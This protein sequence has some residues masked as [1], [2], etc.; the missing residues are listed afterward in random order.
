MAAVVCTPL[1][2]DTTYFGDEGEIRTHALKIRQQPPSPARENIPMKPSSR[3]FPV[4]QCFRCGST[5]HLANAAECRARNLQCRYSAKAEHDKNL[6]SPLRSL[7]RTPNS[8][9][10]WDPTAEKSF[11]KLKQLLLE[12]PALALF[13]PALETIVTTDAS[14]DGIGA[15]LSQ[16]HDGGERT[17][18]F[19][20]HTL[21]A[22]E[23]KYS[24]V[25]K[26]A[27]ACIWAVE[28]WRCWLWADRA[29][30]RIARWSVK[31]MGFNYDVKYKPGYVN[32]VADAHCRLPAINSHEIAE[33]EEDV[34]AQITSEI[35]AVAPSELA[36]ATSKCSVLSQVL[37]YMEVGWPDNEKSLS[38]ELLPFCRVRYELAVRNG[39]IIRGTGRLVI[40]E[41]LQAS[42]IALAHESHQGTVRT[43]ARLRRLFWWPKWDTAVQ[44]YVRNCTVRRTLDKTAVQYRA[45]LNPVPLQNPAWEKLAIDIVGP[46]QNSRYG[47]RLAITLVDYYKL[48]VKFSQNVTT[49]DAIQFL[50]EIF[51]HEGL[52]SEIFSDNGAQFVSNEFKQFLND[53]AI[54]HCRTSLYYP[55]AN[56]EVE[57][58]NRV[59]KHCLQ[60]ASRTGRPR[61]EVVTEFLMHYRA[62]PHAVTGEFSKFPFLTSTGDGAD[63]RNLLAVVMNVTENGFYRLGTA[64]G[65]LN[66]LYARSGFTPCRK[67]LIRIEDVP[68]QE[69]PVRSALIAQSTGSGQGFV[70]YSFFVLIAPYQPSTR[71][72]GSNFRN[73]K[74]CVSCRRYKK[75]YKKLLQKN[76]RCEEADNEERKIPTMHRI[77]ENPGEN[78][79]AERRYEKTQEK[80]RS[81]RE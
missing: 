53:H 41:V 63:A 47:E 7:V 56:G 1:R 15:V 14:D 22:A 55:Q 17:V 42:I 24:V 44:T 38:S 23:R 45:P 73:I 36:D 77:R 61:A 16:V 39:C 65:V 43:K 21:S 80:M 76:L 10:S 12:C 19:A 34:I 75:N 59:L 28:K 2:G 37:R 32:V 29:S 60:L 30:L 3:Q 66:Q 74:K 18:A 13:D 62:T 70:S 54:R 11:Q 52:P 33:Y 67:E 20:S 9:F 50:K 46:L 4:K 72:K 26:E 5:A 8:P 25:E 48:R 57:R 64:Q 27:L 58:L 49:K 31:L 6:N 81:Q 78:M 69:I 71:W 40:P 79:D 51:S 68:N 35:P